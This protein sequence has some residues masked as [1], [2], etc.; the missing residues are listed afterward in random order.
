MKSLS[1]FLSCF[2]ASLALVACGGGGGGGSG[3]SSGTN[4]PDLG[5]YTG[6][7]TPAVLSGTNFEAIAEGATTTAQKVVDIAE[8]SDTA[9]GL[10]FKAVDQEWRSID[11]LQQA[12]I[13]EFSNSNRVDGALAKV[14][15]VSS[16]LC[17]SGGA[18]IDY[19]DSNPVPQN[20]TA[21]ITYDDCDAGG[22]TFDGP[23]IISWDS[24]DNDFDEPIS[25]VAY[26]NLDVTIDG[27][28]T[29]AVT[30]SLVCTN[31]GFS[32]DYQEAFT[33]DGIGYA[34]SNASIFGNAVT[35]YDYSVRL[36]HP[37]YGYVTISASDVVFCEN[38]NLE[39]GT[40]SVTDSTEEDNLD[41]E[42]LSCEEYQLT[43]NSQ[44][45]VSLVVSQ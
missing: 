8:T 35:G 38:G 33:I 2:I 44:A 37:E 4:A 18:V 41:I 31:R 10:V 29:E 7:R 26:L 24:Y 19:P 32:C 23:V 15:D 30:A 45:S 14:E 11:I 28:E 9:D 27:E 36:Y 17:F 1:S 43:Y 12:I 42:I 13:A 22:V 16:E 6:N 34:A 3:S 21:T 20:G 25:Y 5:G 40:L 39:S